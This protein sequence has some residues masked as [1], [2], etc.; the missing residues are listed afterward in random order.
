MSKTL[1]E[2]DGIKLALGDM[3]IAW[4]HLED[5]YFTLA[6][7]QFESFDSEISQALQSVLDIR[8]MAALQKNT[9]L[10]RPRNIIT[11]HLICLADQIDKELRPV[12][13]R[14][15]HDPIFKFNDSYEFVDRTA[16]IR[17][18]QAFKIEIT[19]QNCSPASSERIEAFTKCIRCAHEYAGEIFGILEC[20]DDAAKWGLPLG[21]QEARVLRANLAEA[22]AAYKEMTKSPEP[23]E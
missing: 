15:I 14:F 18:P 1:S 16:R 3:C 11:D 22:I 20:M 2:I 6:L 9:A 21:D 17:K 10:A 23:K 19:F 7:Y 13:N 5:D 8:D 12:R 4:A